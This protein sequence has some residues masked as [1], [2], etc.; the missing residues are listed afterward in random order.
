MDKIVV[1]KKGRIV[2]IGSH[3]ELLRKKR[4]ICQIVLGTGGMVSRKIELIYPISKQSQSNCQTPRELYLRRGI[5]L[6]YN[7]V[8]DFV[9]SGNRTDRAF[10]QFDELGVTE[11]KQQH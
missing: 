5:F 8:Q 2:E 3:E 4:R 6:C 9:W 7:Q 1:M 10:T 11:W